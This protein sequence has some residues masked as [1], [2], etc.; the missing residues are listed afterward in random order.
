MA[1]S[2]AYCVLP[3]RRVVFPGQV[4]SFAI[5]KSPSIA[6]VEHILGILTPGA[7]DGGGG[8][9][10]DEMQRARAQ[11]CWRCRWRVRTRRG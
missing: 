9:A 1:A 3:V 7:R 8:R 11:G 4:C 5:G 6:L 10:L 2:T